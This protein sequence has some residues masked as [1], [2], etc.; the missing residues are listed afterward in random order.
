MRTPSRGEHF[1]S[2]SVT[3]P[4]YASFPKSREDC[5]SGAHVHDQKVAAVATFKVQLTANCGLGL[6]FT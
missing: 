5:K 3:L 4:Q 2:E 6:S 1:C